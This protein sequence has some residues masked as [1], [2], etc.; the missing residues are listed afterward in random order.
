MN[1]L[2]I[3][4]NAKCGE[5]GPGKVILRHYGGNLFDLNK[6]ESREHGF[7]KNSETAEA[8]IFYEQSKQDLGP[9]L[10]GVFPGGRVEEFIES[11]TLTPEEAQTPAIIKDLATCFA[12][13]HAHDLPLPRNK[14]DIMVR[15]I[16]APLDPEQEKEKRAGIAAVLQDSIITA[17]GIDFS[18]MALFDYRSEFKWVFTCLASIP[19]REA[20]TTFDTNFLNVLVR[21]NPVGDQLKTLLIDYEFAMFAFRGLDLGGHFVNRIIKWNGKE[22]KASGHGFPPEPQRRQFVQYYI[23]EASKL[24]KY[25]LDSR[26]TVDYVLMESDLGALLVALF[27]SAGVLRMGKVLLREPSF[28]TVTTLL[29]TFYREHKKVCKE[30]YRNWPE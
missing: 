29:Q 18:S 2:Y 11:H 6:S 21:E 23:D 1:T 7:V 22:T 30:K 9:H 25:T 4:E 8:L 16:S 17:L 26:D 13:F 19:T 12:R 5:A 27:F 3:V 24:V 15:S 20:L 28:I 14:I 10:Y